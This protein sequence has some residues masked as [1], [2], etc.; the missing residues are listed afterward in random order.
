MLCLYQIA[1]E[2]KNNEVNDSIVC[3]NMDQYMELP[4]STLTLLHTEPIFS[5]A[6]L[7]SLGIATLSAMCLILVL[8][9]EF[10]GGE[11]GNWLDVPTG[12]SSSVLAAQ[13]CG[14]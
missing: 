13:Y 11:E 5:I 8:V 6:F 1:D 9:S 10:Q 3:G 7:F 12:I 4:A 2:L 14:E